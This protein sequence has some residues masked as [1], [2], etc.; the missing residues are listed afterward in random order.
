MKQRRKKSL[1][2]LVIHHPD[3]TSGMMGFFPPAAE[4]D[5]RIQSLAMSPVQELPWMKRERPHP[6]NTLF[7]D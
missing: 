2:G 4:T 3:L 1:V 7:P 6:S 5:V